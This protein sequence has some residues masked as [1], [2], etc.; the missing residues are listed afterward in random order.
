MI[1]IRSLLVYTICAAHGFSIVSAGLLKEERASFA[2]PGYVPIVENTSYGERISTD[3]TSVY[4]ILHT[5]ADLLRMQTMVASQTDPWYSAYVNFSANSLASS[6]YI[7]QGPLTYFTRNHSGAQDGLSNIISD[8]RAA[9]NLAL[10][11]GR[12]LYL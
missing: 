5:H 12:F 4:R 8:G 7:M 1:F 6:S 10:R 11:S 2:H 9:V 3:V